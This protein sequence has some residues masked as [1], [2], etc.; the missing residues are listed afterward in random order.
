[1]SKTTE[2]PVTA[3]PNTEQSSKRGLLKLA[4]GIVAAI[5]LTA[6]TKEAAKASLIP[7]VKTPNGTFYP[8]Y[9][10]H[11]PGVKAEKINAL[12][13]TVNTF[14]LEGELMPTKEGITWFQNKE[15]P[16]PGK[17]IY[18]I[19]AEF[20]VQASETLAPHFAIYKEIAGRTRTEVV[21]GDIEMDQTLDELTA[22][23]L[24]EAVGFGFAGIM[25]KYG[26]KIRNNVKA[27]RRDALKMSAIGAAGFVAADPATGTLISEVV[28]VP[29]PIKRITERYAA[30]GSHLHPEQALVLFRNAVWAD[31]LLELA[32][33]KKGKGEQYPHIA[34]VLGAGHAG[35]EDFL[36]AGQEFC[37]DVITLYP[38]WFIKA[39]I[40][41]NREGLTALVANRIIEIG[42]DDS[43]KL[44]LKSDQFVTDEILKN[45]LENK[46]R[47][48]PH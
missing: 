16:P 28:P 1:M 17:S 23:K 47:Q 32:K 15:F 5:G 20:F 36:Q 13:S 24:V 30:I 29:T 22:V 4:G 18:N 21:Y 43:G 31:K 8:L 37:R 9:E 40:E 35:V 25:A 26:E 45:S 42:K 33:Y 19:P 12:P 3:V 6:A 48:L 34:M 10:I 11:F 14:W 27:T 44:Q 2:I 41:R 7:E 39:T 46:T 38:D